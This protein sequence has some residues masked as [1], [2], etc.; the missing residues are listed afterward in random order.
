MSY[1]NYSYSPFYDDGRFKQ[2]TVD[3]LKQQKKNVYHSMMSYIQNL[4]K[5]RKIGTKD[6]TFELYKKKYADS[7]NIRGNNVS[8]AKEVWDFCFNKMVRSETPE[9]I[10]EFNY[11]GFDYEKK[12]KSRDFLFYKDGLSILF[13]HNVKTGDQLST[14]TCVIKDEMNIDGEVC[15]GNEII[16]AINMAFQE[17]G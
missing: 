14:M 13:T 3:Y 4:K 10:K 5:W 15:L 17:R 11:L 8:L 16:R 2:E 7:Y 1:Y 12:P 6:E 9:F